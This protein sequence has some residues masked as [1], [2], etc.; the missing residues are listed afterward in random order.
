M[1]EYKKGCV[2]RDT[3]NFMKLKPHTNPICVQHQRLLNWFAKSSNKITTME[4][5]NTLGIMSPA[6]RILELKQRG[7]IIKTHR[8]DEYDL[9][10]IA[11]HMGVYVYCGKRGGDHGKN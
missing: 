6:A 11:H 5:R 1:S 3:A 9:N 8:V 2:R 7:Y 4:A 10:G